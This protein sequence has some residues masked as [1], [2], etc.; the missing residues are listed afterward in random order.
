MEVA[1]PCPAADRDVLDHPMSMKP[2]D[3]VRS[4]RTSSASF[5]AR[6]SY[7][8]SAAFGGR[9]DRGF[10]LRLAR[11]RLG[12]WIGRKRGGGLRRVGDGRRDG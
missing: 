4:S 3:A 12:R 2:V 9:S 8:G 11:S 5:G 7:S 6:H 1:A 10:S